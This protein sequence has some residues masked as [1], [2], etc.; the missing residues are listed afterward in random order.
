MCACE[1]T[2][3]CEALRRRPWSLSLNRAS[4]WGTSAHPVSSSSS[5]G[6]WGHRHLRAHLDFYKGSRMGTQVLTR[7]Q[8]LLWPLSRLGSAY[9]T[10]LHSKGETRHCN[11]PVTYHVLP[12]VGS[13]STN[14]RDQLLPDYKTT[15]LCM[16]GVQIP[17][18][19][20]TVCIS[21]MIQNMD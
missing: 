3:V 16:T 18:I 21:K 4:S 9:Y 11:V 19:L 10:D 1:R 20:S 6:P 8:Q 15:W 7:E 13:L 12:T 17:Q 14:Y 2:C 5:T